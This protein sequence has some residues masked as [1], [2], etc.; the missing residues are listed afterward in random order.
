MQ[1]E[2]IKGDHEACPRKL[3]VQHVAGIRRTATSRN[4]LTLWQEAMVYNKYDKFSDKLVQL[5]DSNPN[6]ALN[7]SM[8]S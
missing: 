6:C 7:S 4:A 1:G 8:P 5:V 2:A 3:V